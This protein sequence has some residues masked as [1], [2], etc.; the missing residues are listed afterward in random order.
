MTTL[1]YPLDETDAAVKTLLESIDN[2][3]VFFGAVSDADSSTKT[4]GA[5]L[6]Y[7]RRVLGSDF[8][9]NP[10]LGGHGGWITR[11][12]IEHVHGYDDACK[13][14]QSAV[15]GLLDGAPVVVGGRT[16]HI[17][18]YDVGQSSNLEPDQTWTRPGGG[19]LYSTWD[20]YDVL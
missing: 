5:P 17:R 6:P 14:V 16:R 7:V 19:P 11:F 1:T 13:A 9:P 4:I 3:T 20:T 8:D 10:R 12:R 2:L 18:L 15:R